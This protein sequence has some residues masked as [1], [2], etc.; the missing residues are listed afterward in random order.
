MNASEEGR[1][2][3]AEGR[4]GRASVAARP[5]RRGRRQSLRVLSIATLCA[6]L[7]GCSQ[8]SDPGPSSADRALKD[9]MGYGPRAN[10]AD[11]KLKQQPSGFGRDDSLQ[12]DLNNVFNP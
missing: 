5:A 3:R 6:T 9:P 7:S 1:T 11:N 10:P 8:T 4:D 12:R 2:Q